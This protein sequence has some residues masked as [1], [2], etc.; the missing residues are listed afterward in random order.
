MEREERTI[1]FHF[2]PPALSAAEPLIFFPLH[3]DFSKT[4]VERHLPWDWICLKE[5]VGE[6]EFGLAVF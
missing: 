4:T 5:G 6:W 3:V 2:F 1:G